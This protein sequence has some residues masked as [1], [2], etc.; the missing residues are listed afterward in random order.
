MRPFCTRCPSISISVRPKRRDLRAVPFNT[1]YVVYC[2]F[3]P[4]PHLWLSCLKTTLNLSLE[5]VHYG[6]WACGF[7]ITSRRRLICVC[8]LKLTMG[9]SVPLPPIQNHMSDSHFVIIKG[10]RMNSPRGP[11]LITARNSGSISVW[12]LIWRDGLRCMRG[13]WFCGT[14]FTLALL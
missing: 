4:K 12:C 2:S 9:N 6:K 3:E 13:D 5:L 11:N 10:T 7:A 8:F 14:V 1:R